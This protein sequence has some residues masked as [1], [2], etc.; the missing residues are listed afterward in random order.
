MQRT[1]ETLKVTNKCI[2]ATCL[3]LNRKNYFPTVERVL[4]WYSIFVV[5]KQPLTNEFVEHLMITLV[6][7]MVFSNFN[8]GFNTK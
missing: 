6:K 1:H 3:V 4:V 8:I 2:P 7:L 5:Y